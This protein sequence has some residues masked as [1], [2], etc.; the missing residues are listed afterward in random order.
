MASSGQ[1][2][3]PHVVVARVKTLINA[4]LKNVLKGEGL[5]VSGVKSAMQGR[6]IARMFWNF[7]H[8]SHCSPSQL[9][10]S[11]LQIKRRLITGGCSTDVENYARTGNT[12]G[13]NR[14]KN[15]VYSPDGILSPIAPRPGLSSSTKPSNPTPYS[16]VNGSG[17][18]LGSAHLG[19][20]P[21][22]YAPGRI[23]KSPVHGA[24]DC[25]ECYQA[26]LVFKDSP[27]YSIID[28]LT[29]VIECKGESNHRK[30]RTR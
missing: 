6:I 7:L 17:R 1:P 4:H 10:L 12:E 18:P 23:K 2:L 13:F 11:S 25:T 27:F 24:G 26:R 28:A 30:W 14:V 22:A 29:P 16:T 19:M 20:P 8:H 9:L 15:L 5:P 3:D 21:Q